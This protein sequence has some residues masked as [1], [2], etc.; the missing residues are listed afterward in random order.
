MMSFLCIPRGQENETLAGKGLAIQ[1]KT[2]AAVEAYYS[3][4]HGLQEDRM[5]KQM[6]SNRLVNFCFLDFNHRFDRLPRK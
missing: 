4:F 6:L 5:V 2:K 3:E 1:P